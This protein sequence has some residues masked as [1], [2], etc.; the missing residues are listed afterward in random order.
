MG[1]TPPPWHGQAVATQVLFDHDWPE[2]EVHRLRMEYSEEMD[3]VGRFQLRKLKH[4]FSLILKARRILKEHRG[5]IL[6]YPPASAKWIPFLRDVIFLN[7]VRHLAGKTVFIFHASGLPVFADRNPLTRILSYRAYHGAD[8]SLEVATEQVPPHRIFQAWDSAWCPCAIEVGDAVRR[9]PEHG[10]RVAL[11]VGSLQEGKGVLEI[12]RTAAILKDRGKEEE[13]Q[14]RIVGKW[15]STEFEQEARALHHALGLGG[16][17]EFAGQLT[18]DEKWQAYADADVFFFPTHYSSE[19]TPI[20]IMEALGMGLPVLSTEWAGIPAMLVGC[21]SATLLPVRSPES[22]AGALESLPTGPEAK[23]RM[24]EMA[25]AFYRQ[26]FLPE[27]FIE[28]V[29]RAFHIASPEPVGHPLAT[30]AVDIAS[31]GRSSIQDVAAQLPVSLSI[32]LADQNPKLG[33]SLGISRMTEVVMEELQTRTRFDIRGVS[34][35]SSIQANHDGN[36]LVLPWQTRTTLTRLLT[37]HFHPIF[38]WAWQPDVWYFPKGYLPT[39]HTLCSPSVV[40]IHDTIVQYYADR[41]P[42]WRTHTEYR[43]WARMLQHTL[44]H[45]DH[46]LTVSQSSKRQI[47]EFMRRHHLPEKEITVTY[48]PCL[49][50]SIEQPDNPP[51]Q[52]YVLHLASREPHK[53]TAWLVEFWAESAGQ[54]LPPLHVVGTLPDEVVEIA[55]RTAHIQR[56]PF[57]DDDALRAQFLGARALVFPSEIEGFGLPA[58]EAYYLGTPVCFVK[59]T[60]VEE[61]LDVATQSGGFDLDDIGSLHHALDEVMALPVAEVRRIGLKLRETYAASKVVDRMCEI[62]E[63]AAR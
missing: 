20:V 40:T 53:R 54:D 28:R 14:F 22:Y 51:K 48:E 36:H 56:F 5:C 9:R 6:F 2:F 42:E 62:F 31:C 60:S 13:F 26:R 30:P 52:N 35:R 43:Y 10:P 19:A 21:E 34:S 63:I 39:L 16:M 37:D 58:I 57:L 7:A 18:G 3:A 59:G 55:N 49:Y 46:V 27:R 23:T 1:Q 50:E 15:F 24:R 61:V 45:A 32:Y 25:I 4:L 11:F 41:Y 33:R 17:V 8:V 44:R 12:L 29:A 47:L 38:Q